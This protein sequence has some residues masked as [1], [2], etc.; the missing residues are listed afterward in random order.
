MNA[1]IVGGQPA[2]HLEQ[3]SGQGSSICAVVLQ[4]GAGT[5]QVSGAKPQASSRTVALTPATP[6]TTLR[7]HKKKRMKQIKKQVQRGLLDPNKDNP[8]ELFMSST[9]VRLLA[10][11]LC[12]ARL[13][14]AVA[15]TVDSMVLLP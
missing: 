10:C 5:Q 2:L 11:A 13:S 4:E 12:S 8:F 9:Q 3:V 7:S 14:P 6:F 1:A 15:S